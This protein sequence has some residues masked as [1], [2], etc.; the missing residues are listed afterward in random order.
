MVLFAIVLWSKLFQASEVESPSAHLRSLFVAELR[1]F[2]ILLLNCSANNDRNDFN[3][4]LNKY[5]LQA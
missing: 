5:V 3:P 2:Q 4:S 1:F